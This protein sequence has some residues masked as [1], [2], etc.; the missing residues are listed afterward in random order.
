MSVSFSPRFVR[1]KVSFNYNGENHQAGECLINSSGL[2]GLPW[3]S[4]DPNEHL[5]R[6]VLAAVQVLGNTPWEFN[7]E[8]LITS[9]RSG[10]ASGAALG[11]T[12]LFKPGDRAK[13]DSLVAAG[14]IL[15]DYVRRFPRIHFMEHVPVF[16]S[17]AIVKFFY[18]QED[19]AVACDIENLSP[20]G[21]SVITDDARTDTLLPNETVRIQLQPRGPWLR[22]VAV[23]AQIKRITYAVDPLT[24]NVRRHLGLAITTMSAEARATYTDL[25][26]AIVTSARGETPPR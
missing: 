6:R 10:T 19:L 22:A 8:A 15:P 2:P 26:R 4:F 23:N 20:T 18:S 16:P 9:E 24:G 3:K 11:L 14:G 7:C 13:L 21:I 25:L 5:G 1:A 12:F 17:R